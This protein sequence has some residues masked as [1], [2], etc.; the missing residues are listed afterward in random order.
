MQSTRTDRNVSCFLFPCFLPATYNTSTYDPCTERILSLSLRGAT[1]PQ[2]HRPDAIETLI[3]SLDFSKGESVRAYGELY[4][5]TLHGL[6]LYPVPYLIHILYL[7]HISFIPYTLSYYQRPT[8][9]VP[10]AQMIVPIKY[11]NVI[12]RGGTSLEY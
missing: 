12:H 4:R 9:A 5:S 11:E 6:S 10:S 7:M 8:S 2:C 1:M 3:S